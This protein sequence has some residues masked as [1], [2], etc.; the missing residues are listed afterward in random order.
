MEEL[1]KLFSDGHKVEILDGRLN[2]S[3]EV[4]Q[5]IDKDALLFEIATV[6][7]TEL[8]I[9]Q[10]YSAGAY[11]GKYKGVTLQFNRSLSEQG[12]YAIFNA[13]IVRQR[14]S[15]KGKKGE[16]LPNGHFNV[17]ENS[18]FYKFWKRCYLPRPASL[19][20]FWER[21]GN[22]KKVI[23]TGSYTK[24][25]RLDS[26]SLKPVDLSYIEIKECFNDCHTHKE[27]INNAQATHKE[28]IRP[29]HKEI[30]ENHTEQGVQANQSTG[31]SK[32]GNKV[33][34]E[35]GNKGNDSISITTTKKSPQKQSNDEW[36]EDWEQF[37]M[38]SME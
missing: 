24:G 27:R 5:S 9:Y 22:L 7:S 1:A 34:R 20:R 17:S 14:N 10:S 2:I 18:E 3:P 33:I 32:Y 15:K 19:T 26:K 38:D 12:A 28:R 16:R 25:E 35:C 36:L 11:Q 13:N 30:D 6:T 8:L 21:M 37:G 4:V 31:N 23:L 29:T